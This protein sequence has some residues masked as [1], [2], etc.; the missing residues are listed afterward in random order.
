M[1]LAPPFLQNHIAIEGFELQLYIGCSPQEQETRQPVAI[2]IW[3]LFPKPPLGCIS[4]DLKDTIC[5]VRCTD[6]IRQE[7]F[8]EKFHLIEY[9]AARIH[10]VL[11][12]ELPMQLQIVVRV[13][14]V[15]SAVPDVKKHIRFT[16]FPPPQETHAEK[17]SSRDW[18]WD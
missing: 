12:K 1:N 3:I 8:D 9:L 14:K 5:Y 7:L 15:R 6:I 13:G 2:D 18:T 17:K 10:K 4:D 16:Y 11:K